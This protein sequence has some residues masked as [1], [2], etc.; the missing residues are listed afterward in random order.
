MFNQAGKLDIFE[1]FRV[2]R[3]LPK[4]KVKTTKDSIL[5]ENSKFEI[6]LGDRDVV[7][8]TQKPKGF[9]DRLKRLFRKQEP[10]PSLTVEQ[11]FVST[12]QTMQ[13]IEVVTERAQGYERAILEAQQTGQKALLENLQNNLVG[14]K[15]EARLVSL[16]LNKYL[17]ED[18]VVQLAKK[19][20]KGL[21]LDWITNFTRYI[22]DNLCAL[23]LQ[24][25]EL[26][27]FDNYVI[28]HY[29]PLAKSWAETEKE[30]LARK[31]DPIL[32][33]V[34]RGRRRLYYIGDWID[35]FC[36]LT[37]DQVADILGK[38]SINVIELV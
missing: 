16:G 27:I 2:D 34:M 5:N 14:I 28:L 20:T 13:Q 9:W 18:T 37:L 11:F 38:E 26:G 10:R 30:R 23:K 7:I 12:K 21:R 32:F 1:N 6:M 25:D 8:T 36:D 35:E 4:F 29:D 15:A 17:N 31:R 24:C 19:A 3:E 22:P 33:G